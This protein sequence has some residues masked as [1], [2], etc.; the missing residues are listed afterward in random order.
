MATATVT[1][2]ELLIVDVRKLGFMGGC[3]YV[4]LVDTAQ[5]CQHR[6]SKLWLASH[7]PIVAK[8]VAV[9]RFSDLSTIDAALARSADTPDQ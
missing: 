4:A 3:A 8:I 9:C 1:M 5:Q 2:P 6:G 7:Q